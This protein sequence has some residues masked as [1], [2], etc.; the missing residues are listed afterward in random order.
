[1]DEAVDTANIWGGEIYFVYFP[2]AARY[3]NDAVHPYAWRKYDDMIDMVKKKNIKIIDLRKYVF[4]KHEDI[5]SLYPLRLNGH[6]NEKGYDLVA[7][8]IFDILMEK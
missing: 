8:H 4:D 5:K 6:P 3:F 2:H 7:K 1:M